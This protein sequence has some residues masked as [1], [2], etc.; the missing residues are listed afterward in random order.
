VGEKT[1][2]VTGAAGALGAAVSRAACARGWNVVMVDRDR[3]G[4][5]RVF[6]SLGDDSPGA[7][8]LYPMDLAGV[9]PDEIDDLLEAVHEAYGRLDAVIHCAAHFTGLTPL[10]HFDPAE[11]LMH[12]Q[13]NVNAPWLLSA[14]ALRLLREAG[15]GKIVFVL[16]DL[17]KVGGPLWGAYGVSK[18][19]LAALVRQLAAEVRSS[20]IEVR[21]V[22]PGPMQS[23]LRT[24]V[25]HS[26]HPGKA[27]DPAQAAGQIVDYV[28]GLTPWP[29]ETV[30]LSMDG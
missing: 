3:G 5:E 26:E 18:H 23:A 17:D 30:D 28:D 10:E 14:R 7:P 16:E 11:W 6:D 21:G 15:S 29:T 2:I 12:M 9:T 8:V 25:Y 22:N 4:L 27:P 20:G 1:M 24:K 19:A 13:S